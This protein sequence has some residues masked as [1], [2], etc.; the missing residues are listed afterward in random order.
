M[1]TDP[2]A[3]PLLLEFDKAS[4]FPNWVTEQIR[5]GNEQP[6]NDAVHAIPESRQKDFQRKLET[7]LNELQL[8]MKEKERDHFTERLTNPPKQ[9]WVTL[10][11][12]HNRRWDVHTSTFSSEKHAAQALCKWLKKEQ[13]GTLTESNAGQCQIE[14]PFTLAKCRQIVQGETWTFQYYAEVGELN[15]S[16]QEMNQEINFPPERIFVNPDANIVLTEG[17]QTINGAKTFTVPDVLF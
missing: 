6:L 2:V 15:I 11:F 12:N 13:I 5:R 17:S 16:R 7:V 1:D 10:K 4:W 9:S 3:S 14:P 8:D